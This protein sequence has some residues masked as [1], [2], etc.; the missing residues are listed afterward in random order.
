MEGQ[1]ETPS[2]RVREKICGPRN[3][4]SYLEMTGGL[5]DMAPNVPLTARRKEVVAKQ[6]PQQ[7]WPPKQG[8]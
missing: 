6:N 8:G 5:G 3:V 2:R 7:L 1:E 4:H